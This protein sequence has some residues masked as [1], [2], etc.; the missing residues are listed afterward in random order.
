MNIEL[1]RIWRET[2]TTIVLVTHSIAEAVYLGNR[3]EVMSAR[4]GRIIRT[5]PVDLPE[6]RNYGQTM[7]DPEFERLTS[8]IRSLLGASGGHE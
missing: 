3:V 1:H 6:H 7:V 5:L 4:P 2:G 8:T